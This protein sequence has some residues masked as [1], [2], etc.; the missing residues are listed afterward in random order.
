MIITAASAS[1]PSAVPCLRK[2]FG[3]RELL[4][5]VGAHC[6]ASMPAQ[7]SSTSRA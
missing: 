5:V 3:R 6:A 2:P 7:A 1:A 4:D